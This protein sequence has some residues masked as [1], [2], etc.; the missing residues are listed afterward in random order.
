MSMLRGRDVVIIEEWKKQILAKSKGI[1]KYVDVGIENPSVI[2]SRIH[3]EYYQQNW[4]NC[5]IDDKMKWLLEEEYKIYLRQSS[6]AG[7]TFLQNCEVFCKEN[8]GKFPLVENL[9]PVLGI[10]SELW[11]ALSILESSLAQG[12]KTRAGGSLESHLEFLLED[13]GYKKGIDFSTQ[14]EIQGLNKVRLDFLFP[15]NSSKLISNPNITVTCACMT[16]VNDRVRLAIQQLQP[17][18]FRRVPTAHGA[19]QFK[20]QLRNL[21]GRMDYAT[22]NQFRFIVLPEVVLYYKN[23]DT[24]MTYQEW[25]DEIEKLRGAW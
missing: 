13:S 1:L 10:T 7:P 18:T 22:K 21:G 16:T 11:T 8:S 19:V 20:N 6:Q 14:E 9:F 15:A 3:N 12:R 25:F 5:T 2:R 24:L 17:N 23:H 4:N